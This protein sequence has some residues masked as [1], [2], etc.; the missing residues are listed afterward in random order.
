MIEPHDHA[1]NA[2]TDPPDR[3]D[4]L[5]WLCG[6]ARG[7]PAQRC[8]ERAR[9]GSGSR[10]AHRRPRAARRCGRLPGQPG[11]GDHRHARLLP[12]ARRRRPDVRRDRRGQRSVGRVRDGRPGAVRAV[13]RGIPRG[14]ATGH[15][16]GDLRRRV[17]QG[18]R[19]GRHAGRWPHDPRPGAEVWPRGDRRGAPRP[20]AA[21]GRRAARRPAAADQA[22]R[23]RRARVGLAPGTD[24]ARGPRR[25]SRP[26]AGAEPRQPRRRSSKQA[27]RRRPT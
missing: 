15:I 20:A 2:P 8:A 14:P 25:C 18:A 1:R 19:G 23:D 12:A 17:G 7:G 27:S 9:G 21:Q 16:G 13:D 22:P 4:R 11:A 24:R 26:D 10:R 3:A 6:E 5:W